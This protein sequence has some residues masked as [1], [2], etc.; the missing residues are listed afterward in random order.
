MIKIKISNGYVGSNIQ[1][2]RRVIFLIIVYA[3][4]CSSRNDSI[5]GTRDSSPRKVVI[6]LY[7]LDN[8][9]KQ[10]S[11]WIIVPKINKC[12]IDSRIRVIE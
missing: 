4:D 10:C 2:K 9:S 3:Y 12:T 1:S 8:I 5:L 11:R 7:Y 6:C